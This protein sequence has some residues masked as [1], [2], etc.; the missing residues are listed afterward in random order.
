M[1]TTQENNENYNYLQLHL[2]SHNVSV[3]CFAVAIV[4]LEQSKDELQTVKHRADELDKTCRNAEAE[5]ETL[6]STVEAMERALEQKETK[7]ERSLRDMV[8]L[9]EDMDR[10]LFDKDEELQNMR[11]PKDWQ[12]AS[13]L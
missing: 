1:L 7:I 3:V 13:L 11:Y 10:R 12:C 8:S 9:K 5:K 4:E 2:A 6:K